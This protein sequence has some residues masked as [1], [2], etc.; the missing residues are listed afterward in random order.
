MVKVPMEAF[1]DQILGTPNITVRAHLYHW[2]NAPDKGDENIFPTGRC[3][4]G[5][6][7]NILKMCL[8]PLFFQEE[9]TD[10]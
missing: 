10:H 7:P 5:F 2:G 1:E 3:N 9:V 8:L 6:R 4:K